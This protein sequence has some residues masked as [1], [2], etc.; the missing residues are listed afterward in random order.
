VRIPQSGWIREPDGDGSAHRHGPFRD[1]IKRSSRHDRV[2]RS[3]DDL[4]TAQEDTLAHVLFSTAPDDVGLYDKPMARNAQIWTQKFDLLLDGPAAGHDE[5]CRAARAVEGGGTFGYR[6]ITPAMRVGRH[7]VYWHRPLVAFRTPG[8]RTTTLLGAPTGYL[9][10]YP[11]DR[12]D[13]R[14]PVELWPRL[15]RCDL[16]AEN[17]DLFLDADEDPP[18]QTLLNVRKIV[19]SWEMFGGEPLPRSFARHLL[20]LDKRKSLDDW[21]RAL[22]RRAK[23]FKRGRRLAA[24]VEKLLERNANHPSPTPP[25]SGEGRSP[26]PEA[27]D[28]VAPLPTS[29]RGRGRGNGPDAAASLTFDQTAA[30]AFEVAYWTAIAD[31][32][33][34]AFANKNNAD[35]VLDLPTQKALRH[36][37]RDLDPLGDYLLARHRRLIDEHGMNGKAVAGDLPFRWETDLHYPWMG[38]W[39]DNQSGALRE[40]NLLVLIPGRDRSRAVILADHYDTA[41]MADHYE[42]EQGGTGAR[43]A[44]PGADDNCS[45]TA[46]LLMAAPVFLDMS[47]AGRLGC[48]VWLLH[49]TGEEY[50]AEGLGT[51]HLCRELVEGALRLRLADGGWRDLSTAQIR[52][53]YVMDMIAHNSRSGRDVFQISPGASRES[54]W[55]AYQAHEANRVWNESVDGWNKRRP[56]AGRFRRQR[57]G[58]AVPAVSPHPRLHGEVRPTYDPRSTLYNTDGQMFSDVGVPVVL[59]MENYDISRSGYHDSKD[60]LANIDLDYGAALAAIAIEATARAATA[61]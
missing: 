38:G 2:A 19:Q 44:T 12:P 27:T 15:L 1:S 8:G 33:T 16:H 51:C 21:L 4:V 37:A 3:D 56:G 24:E 7:D 28:P 47:R 46:A 30:R 32:S 43:L 58:R 18:L 11:A 40:R 39:K 48:D 31:L 29:G 55:L 9:T 17:V 35:C 49:L 14:R 61:K 41:Y 60:T 5:I 45:A 10:A 22:P 59:F 34:G 13:L 20:T 50:P 52:G 25:R 26:Q 6:I 53:L 54:L 36:P 57:H 23:D 42:K